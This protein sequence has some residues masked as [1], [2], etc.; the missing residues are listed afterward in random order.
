MAKRKE[1][2][3]LVLDP[4]GKISI[5]LK[6]GKESFYG[7]PKWKCT[8]IECNIRT[9]NI[10]GE[11]GAAYRPLNVGLGTRNG[12]HG[13]IYCEGAGKGERRSS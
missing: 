13:V 10:F 12:T 11:I 1:V 6:K 3:C 4:D 5:N 8:K 7:H 9:Q 2:P